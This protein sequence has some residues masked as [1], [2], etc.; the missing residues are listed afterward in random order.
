MHIGLLSLKLHLPGCNSLKEKRRRL[1]GLRD[2]FGKTSNIAVSESAHHDSHQ[3]AEW[4][5]IIASSDK[6]IIEQQMAH[7]D[8]HVH[9]ELDAVLEGSQVEWL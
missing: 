5:F 7:I 6:S 1:L 8:R 3:S 4:S 2:K 9:T